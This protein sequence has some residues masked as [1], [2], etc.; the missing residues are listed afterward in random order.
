MQLCVNI[1]HVFNYYQVDLATDAAASVEVGRSR[2]ENELEQR[3]RHAHAQ[4][5]HD[6]HVCVCA[7]VC[8]SVIFN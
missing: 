8:V 3:L 1:G 4:V 7:E 6:M 2:R 5:A